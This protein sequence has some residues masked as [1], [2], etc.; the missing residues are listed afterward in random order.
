MQLALVDMQRRVQSRVPLPWLQVDPRMAAG[1]AGGR[2]SARALQGHSARMER[3]PADL[4]ADR[5]HP[6][7]LR[8]ARA[9]RLRSHCRAGPRRQRARAAR[10]AA[11]TTP[12][13]ASRPAPIRRTARRPTRRRA[14]IR[15]WC[16]RCGRFSPGA[17]RRW[18]SSIDFGVVAARA[19]SGLRLGTRLCGGDAER[20]TAAVLRTLSRAVARSRRSPARSAPTTIA[21]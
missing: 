16:W 14:S 18:R 17:P 6:A 5:R 19:L 13:P 2:P 20:R 9:R 8:R 7:A 12:R 4:P 3:L 15:C 10:P 21:R 11:G 1:A